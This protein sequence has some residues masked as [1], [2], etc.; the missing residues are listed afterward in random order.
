M[1][2][3]LKVLFEFRA[4][5]SFQHIQATQALRNTLDSPSLLLDPTPNTP[6]TAEP[7]TSTLGGAFIYFI[8]ILSSLCQVGSTDSLSFFLLFN[9][10]RAQGQW[11]SDEKDTSP[12]CLPHP[13]QSLSPGCLAF[14]F[15]AWQLLWG[16]PNLVLV[17]VLVLVLIRDPISFITLMLILILIPIA[18]LP[19]SSIQDECE[20]ISLC[21]PIFVGPLAAPVLKRL[22]V[23]ANNYRQ[24]FAQHHH[25]PVFILFGVHWIALCRRRTAAQDFWLSYQRLGVYTHFPQPFML[26]E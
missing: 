15:N 19:C 22:K 10:S 11:Q 3:S 2:R 26:F 20:K 6:T 12:A 9:F 23:A 16:F 14:T 18:R 1:A 25:T 7:S 5:K 4:R 8:L 13:G 24:I 17:L 21:D